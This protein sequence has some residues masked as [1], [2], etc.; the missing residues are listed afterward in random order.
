[1]PK[2]VITGLGLVTPVGTGIKKSWES[3]LR[4]RS[5]ANEMKS[6]DTSKYKVHRS[7]DVK[8]FAMDV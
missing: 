4:G 2:V 8:D 3:F 5:G 1:M 7:G 6:F